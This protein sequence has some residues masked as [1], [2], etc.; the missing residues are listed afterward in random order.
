MAV[1][2]NRYGDIFNFKLQEDNSI[3]WEGDFKHCRFG[4]P[5][6][7]SLAYQNYCRDSSEIGIKP[8]FIDSFKEAV[9]EYNIETSSYTPLSKRYGPMV[10][11]ITN[12]INMVDPS[13]GPYI[14]V[15]M[16][17]GSIDKEFKGL[18][19]QSIVPLDGGY[20]INTVPEY[21]HLKEWTEILEERK[22]N[23]TPWWKKMS[24]NS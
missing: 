4:M 5:N 23:K 8:M 1:Y 15:G 9:H 12:Q 19:V 20:Q 21:D 3:L 6:D 13:G 2:S 22:L 16:S 24:D 7:Y 14:K 10:K 18:I 17:M 11:S